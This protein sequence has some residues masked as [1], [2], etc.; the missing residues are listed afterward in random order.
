MKFWSWGL[1][2]KQPSEFARLSNKTATAHNEQSC[3]KHHIDC[4]APSAVE[5]RLE[6]IDFYESFT[7]QLSALDTG[8]I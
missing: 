6:G 7:K 1:N 3:D 2:Q 8:D 4:Y 5:G